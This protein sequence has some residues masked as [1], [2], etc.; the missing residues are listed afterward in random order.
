MAISTG[1]IL[2]NYI[3]KNFFLYTNFRKWLLNKNN[4]FEHAV[5]I[6][7]FARKQNLS[8]VYMDM[9]REFFIFKWGSEN[10]YFS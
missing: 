9:L 5:L 1:G 7:K 4:N 8:K 2:K 10:D 3:S 6:M